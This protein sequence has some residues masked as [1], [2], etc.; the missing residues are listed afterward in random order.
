M[1]ADLSL[2]EPMLDNEMSKKFK[3]L[4]MGSTKRILPREYR[5]LFGEVFFPKTNNSN[6]KSL[7]LGFPKRVRLQC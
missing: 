3:N 4:P 6:K 1:N 2:D 7:K 5:N